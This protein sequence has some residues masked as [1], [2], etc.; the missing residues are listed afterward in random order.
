[1]VGD[2][3]TADVRGALACGM[4]AVYLGAETGSDYETLPDVRAFGSWLKTHV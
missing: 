4:Q 2:N 3:L 1:M